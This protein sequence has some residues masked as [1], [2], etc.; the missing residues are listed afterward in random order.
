[1]NLDTERSEKSEMKIERG[2]MS[3]EEEDFDKI[4]TESDGHEQRT[5]HF[6]KMM[7]LRSF[8]IRFELP[9]AHIID[10]AVFARNPTYIIQVIK[11]IIPSERRTNLAI[12]PTFDLID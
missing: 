10:A 8:G 7:Y 11:Y 1:M 9:T 3:D 4:A 2:D 6:N 5:A 12:Y